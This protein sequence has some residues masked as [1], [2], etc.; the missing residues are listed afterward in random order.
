MARQS[1]SEAGLILQ[2]SPWRCWGCALK[3]LQTSAGEVGGGEGQD[4]ANAITKEVDLRI[5]ES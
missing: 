2:M 1:S 3:R 5:E 4:E